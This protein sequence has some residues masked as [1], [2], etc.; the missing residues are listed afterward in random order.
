MKKTTVKLRLIGSEDKEVDGYLFNVTGYTND[1]IVHQES[2]FDKS[3]GLIGDW[4]VTEKSCGFRFPLRGHYE[5]ELIITKF[6][7]IENV[8]AILY[9]ID[10]KQL[11]EE[12]KNRTIAHRI[13]WI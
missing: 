2:D 1:F 7:A 13:S 8:K 11:D 3:L 4:W 10:Q 9:K 12:I 5:D 6:M